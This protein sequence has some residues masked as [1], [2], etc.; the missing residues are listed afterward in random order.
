MNINAKAVS[1]ISII[2]ALVLVFTIVGNLSPSIT[3][4]ADNVTNF[5]Q[6]NTT[7]TQ[8]PLQNLFSSNGI[9]LIVMMAGLLI[10][11]VGFLLKK[12]G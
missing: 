10:G 7:G 5:V 8:L 11:M 6:D 9:I 12:R 2:L 4:A 1:V 3:D